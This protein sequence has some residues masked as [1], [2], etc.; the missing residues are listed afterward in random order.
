MAARLW[1][2][3]THLFV[4]A[5]G[6]LHHLLTVGGVLVALVMCKR[7]DVVLVIFLFL[8]VS[9]FVWT[10]VS[11]PNRRVVYGAW[12]PFSIFFVALSLEMALTVAVRMAPHVRSALRST[13]VKG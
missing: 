3:S 5:Q 11:N 9:P 10:A 4:Q 12:F 6:R 13:R 2:G 7:R 1:C 8:S